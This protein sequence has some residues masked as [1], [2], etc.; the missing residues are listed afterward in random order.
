MTDLHALT[1]RPSPSDESAAGREKWSAEFARYEA[2]PEGW[3]RNY[4]LAAIKAHT[5]QF[6]IERGRSFAMKLVTSNQ[7]D[8]ADLPADLRI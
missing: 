6:G 7:I 4:F 5:D 2:D 1:R 3:M 8:E